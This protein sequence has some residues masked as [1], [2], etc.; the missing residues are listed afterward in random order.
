MYSFLRSS[1][2]GFAF[3]SVSVYNAD[4]YFE[5]NPAGVY[6]V[7]S[8]TGVRDDDGSIT[9]RFG[10]HGPGTPNAIPITDGWNYLVRL[11]RPRPDVS[12]DG[13]RFVYASTAGAADQYNNLYV[14]PTV[15]GEPYKLTFFQH[16]AFHPRWKS[17]FSR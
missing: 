16:D 14:Q 8:V 7:N 4:G 9:V 12:I 5:P 15:G 11:Y 17:R 1:Q 6:S 10:D 2:G 13:K 3:W